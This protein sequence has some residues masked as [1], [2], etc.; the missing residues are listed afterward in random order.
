ME[1][2]SETTQRSMLYI[3]YKAVAVECD[4]HQCAVVVDCSKCRPL[5]GMTSEQNVSIVK[6]NYYCI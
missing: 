6:Y 2:T 5:Y 3:Q 1:T 4:T